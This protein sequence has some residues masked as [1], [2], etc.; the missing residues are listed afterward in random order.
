MPTTVGPN[1]LG[2]NSLVFAYD[3]GDKVN[4]YKGE[5]TTNVLPS[6]QVLLTSYN[7]HGG[8]HT[9]DTNFTL[10]GN[11]SLRTTS[12][13]AQ[14]WN[15]VY[16]TGLSSILTPGVTYTYSFYIY[17]TS[18]N[19]TISY[20]GYGAPGYT[21]VK[22]QWNRVSTTFTATTQDY[23]YVTLQYSLG[24]PVTTYYL[25]NLQI[26]AK[27][28]ATQFING[29]RSATQGL[30][31]I[32]SNASLDLSN[33]SFNSSA[34]ITFDGTN[35]YVDIG[36][37]GT[38]GTEYSIECIFNSSAVVNYRNVFDM[39]Y[40]TYAGVTGNVGPRLEQYS[41]GTFLIGWSGITN[42][43][44]L[45]VGTTPIAISANT[46]YHVTFVQNGLNG[47]IY[48][49]GVYRNQ[50]S[51]TYGY[52]QTFGDVNLGRGFQLTGDRYF[53]GSLPVLKIYN[54]ALTS[55]EVQQ[56]YKQYKSRFNIS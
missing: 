18:D 12:N 32:I 25:A 55:A 28:H 9:T 26:E 30:L 24:L 47:S 23:L 50:T 42:N 1:I 29:T 13:P 46:N 51:N 44:S 49:N 54:R 5:P 19:T 45:S 52:I 15:G 41:D 38:I 56:N 3:T 35:D 2:D 40:A 53:A 11:A 16:L 34:Q 27:S 14:D 20:F 31:P 17:F 8:S 36:N 22:G 4:S 43:N 10:F 33:V 21:G 6:N 48:L 39:N 7:D 37:L